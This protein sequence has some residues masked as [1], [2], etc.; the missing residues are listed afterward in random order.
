MTRPSAKPTAPRVMFDADVAALFGISVNTPQRRIA[1]PA[2]GES[3]PND[4]R[5]QMIGSRRL[6]LREDV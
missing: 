4:A 1:T 2:K 5:P 6:W 3:N